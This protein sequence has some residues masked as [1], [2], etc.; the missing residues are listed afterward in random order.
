MQGSL[1]CACRWRAEAPRELAPRAPPLFTRHFSATVGLIYST[2]QSTTLKLTTQPS[3]CTRM[4]PAALPGAAS[5]PAA[6]RWQGPPPAPPRLPPPPRRRRLAG[7]PLQL[8]LPLAP[9]VAAMLRCRSASRGGRKRG[10]STAR[11]GGEC[12]EPAPLARLR[13]SAVLQCPTLRR[14][15]EPTL[16]APGR[17]PA[18]EKPGRGGSSG[19]LREA[20][21]VRAAGAA[22]P[23]P[24]LNVAVFIAGFRAAGLGEVLDVR[25]GVMRAMFPDRGAGA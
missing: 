2:L 22:R 6:R 24:T 7:P 10:Q 11:V 4:P 18:A 13:G 12:R 21:C 25:A 8:P 23:H 19:L 16:N 5:A 9:A 20:A 15:R 17:S 3:T 14:L 1:A